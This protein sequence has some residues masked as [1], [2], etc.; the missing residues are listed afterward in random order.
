MRSLVGLTSNPNAI[1]FPLEVANI[2]SQC[3]LVADNARSHTESATESVEQLP[4]LRL[5]KN[6]KRTKSRS[7]S[8]VVGVRQ[9]TISQGDRWTAETVQ[10]FYIGLGPLLASAS[11]AS[12]TSN[13]SPLNCSND[14]HLSPRLVAPRRLP[15]SDD[16]CI[17]EKLTASPKRP[18]RKKSSINM[19]M[20]FSPRIIDLSSPRITDLS[21]RK[22]ERRTLANSDS[23]M[24]TAQLIRN[25]LAICDLCSDDDSDANREETT[26]TNADLP[27]S[28]DAPLV[29]VVNA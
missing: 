21:P 16:M 11:S 10:P 5:Y 9:P 20:A 19:M 15:S 17:D 12:A 2:L 22:P 14:H 8:N 26:N 18:S 27:S 3:T 29:N 13:T 24:M 4:P 25:A 28:T 1:M 6:L 23:H 7:R